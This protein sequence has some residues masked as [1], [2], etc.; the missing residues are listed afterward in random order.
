VERV[1]PGGSRLSGTQV[2]AVLG[3]LQFEL[4]DADSEGL[5]PLGLGEGADLILERGVLRRPLCR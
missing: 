1:Q 4:D 5:L 2:G 3:H